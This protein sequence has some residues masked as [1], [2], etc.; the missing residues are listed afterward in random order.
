MKS[1]R[2]IFLGTLIIFSGS[3]P[4]KANEELGVA[5][6]YSH[7]H[8]GK[9]VSGCNKLPKKYCRFN[10]HDL[11]AAHKY[12]KFG[13]IVKVINLRTKAFVNVII[14]DRGPFNSRIIDLSL[15]AAKRLHM[16]DKGKDFVKLIY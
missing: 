3:T 16:V 2:E 4:T 9:M 8:H 13:T 6:F 1:I 12:I 10:M 5:S 7:K 11:T 14:T 15:E